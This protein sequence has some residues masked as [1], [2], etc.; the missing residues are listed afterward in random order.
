M[1]SPALP[2]A[3]PKISGRAWILAVLTLTYTFNHVDRQI[4]VILLEPIKTELGLRDSQLGMLSGLAFAAFYATLGIPVAMWADRGNRRNIIAIALGLWSAMTALSGLAQ[5]YWHLLLARM[6]VGVGEA[7][8]TPPATSMIADLYPPQE[9]ATALGIYTS[10]IGIGI[11]AGFAIG[12]YVNELFGWRVAFFVAGIPGLILALIVRFGIREPVRGLADQRTDD[13]PAPSL[14]ET[15]KFIFSQ[16]S[17]LWLMA[18][19]LLICVSA[20][21]FLVFT[22]S[23]LQRTYGLS[24]GQVSLPLGILIGG[25]GS[26]GAIVLG[27]VCDTLSKKDLRWRPLII[28]LCAAIALPF[29][30]M[31][32][33]APTVEMAYVWNIVPSFIGLIYASVAYTAS[34]ELVKLR[35]RSFA[36]AFMLFCLTLIG[37]GCGPWI[38]GVLSDHFAGAGAAQPLARSLEIILL[39]NASSIVCLLMATRSYRKDAARAAL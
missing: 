12:G 2:H 36:S 5:N 26:V 9:R 13:G 38:A 7:G 33:R 32:L 25:V 39:F 4:L 17:Y 34:Q 37:I 23:H 14:G 35:M 18:G 19:C 27:R 6:G 24:P 29:A 11:M 31:F 28:A 3:A 21:A 10:G 30:W 1:T 8:G 16:S 15:L 22:S 20:N